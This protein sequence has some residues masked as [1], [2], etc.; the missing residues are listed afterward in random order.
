ME[1]EA[2]KHGLW[3]FEKELEKRKCL[4]KKKKPILAPINPIYNSG[5]S[6]RQCYSGVIITALCLICLSAH[7]MR[8]AV[9][10]ISFFSPSFQLKASDT[11]FLLFF[12]F[13]FLSPFSLFNCSICPFLFA[14]G[15]IFNISL[16]PMSP[17]L[18]CDS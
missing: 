4:E 3:L 1:V 14:Q 16:G 18:P 9:S 8:G 11:P 12:S 6:Y 10:F 13:L 17:I 2:F 15:G 5:S 7:G